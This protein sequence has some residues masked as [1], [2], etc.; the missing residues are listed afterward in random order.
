MKT[1]NAFILRRWSLLLISISFMLVPYFFPR[2]RYPALFGLAFIGLICMGIY[3]NIKEVADI[4]KTKG[5]IAQTENESDIVRKIRLALKDPPE[6]TNLMAWRSAVTILTACLIAG[7]GLIGIF[8][9][10]FWICTMCSVID[11]NHKL[12]KLVWE[13]KI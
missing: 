5:T 2:F 10:I 3:K 4:Y 1:E 8:T 6:S 13:N 12:R 11:A 7:H 9:A